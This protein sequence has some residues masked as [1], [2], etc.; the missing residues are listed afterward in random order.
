MTTIFTKEHCEILEYVR[1]GHN[2]LIKGQAGTGKLTIVNAIREDCKQCGLK[3][4]LV[5]SSVLVLLTGKHL[6]LHKCSP[7]L[8][9]V[10]FYVI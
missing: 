7:Y 6:F 4:A 8:Q 2:I 1:S 3:V 5:C 10:I 9:L